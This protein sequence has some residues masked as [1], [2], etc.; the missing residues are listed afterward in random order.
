M[1]LLTACVL[2]VFTCVRRSGRDGTVKCW[3][4]VTLQSPTQ[5]PTQTPLFTMFTG[6]MHFCNT[7][8]DKAAAAEHSIVCTPCANESEVNWG[9]RY[10]CVHACL[11]HF[12]VLVCVR[13]CVCTCVCF[14]LVGVNMG[15][16]QHAVSRPEGVL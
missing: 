1:D 3:D 5:S 6:A 13:M 2:H 8:T 4:L 16:P 7:C 11:F 15:S 9:T 14:V 10:L 12:C